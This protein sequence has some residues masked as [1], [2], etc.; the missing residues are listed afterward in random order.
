VG[1]AE[2][3]V[4]HRGAIFS[5]SSRQA[6]KIRRSSV[7]LHSFQGIRALPKCRMCKPCARNNL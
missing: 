4:R 7:G 3:L 2:C 5:P 1:A 6:T